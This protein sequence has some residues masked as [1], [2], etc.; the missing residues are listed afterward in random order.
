MTLRIDPKKSFKFNLND[1]YTK[2]IGKAEIIRDIIKSIPENEIIDNKKELLAFAE[3]L[4]IILEKL[5]TQDTIEARGL[6]KIIDEIIEI[7]VEPIEDE[8]L[9]NI[10]KTKAIT[11][12]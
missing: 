4:E 10:L 5:E 12:L 6:S 9:P 1:T 11:I 7:I 8:W 2:L 3:N